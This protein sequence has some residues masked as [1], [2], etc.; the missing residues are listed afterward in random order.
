MMIIFGLNVNPGDV[1]T[2]KNPFI[3]YFEPSHE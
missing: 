2:N 1:P 3:A